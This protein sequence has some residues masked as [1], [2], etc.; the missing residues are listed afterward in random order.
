M[1][2]TFLW[3]SSRLLLVTPARLERREGAT[4]DELLGGQDCE[5]S[6]LDK[7]CVLLIDKPLRG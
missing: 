1:T 4:T 3:T 5:G 2:A 7:L 6:A